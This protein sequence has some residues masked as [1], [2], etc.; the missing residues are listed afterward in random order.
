[1]HE[2]KKKSQK[3]EEQSSQNTEPKSDKG[4][5]MAL[6]RQ[7]QVRISQTKDETRIFELFMET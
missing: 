6:L 4:N 1:M 3:E 5:L 7:G 2:S